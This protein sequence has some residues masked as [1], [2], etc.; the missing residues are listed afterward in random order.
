[1]FTKIFIDDQKRQIE[2]QGDKKEYANEQKIKDAPEV[3]TIEYTNENG[4]FA[5]TSITENQIG[6]K[7]N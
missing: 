2:I 1:M 3:F 7:E 5:V 6:K 4:R